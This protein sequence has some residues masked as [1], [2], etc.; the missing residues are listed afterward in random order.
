MRP[1]RASGSVITWWNAVA[2]SAAGASIKNACTLRLMA[3]LRRAST[4]SGARR[5]N[6]RSERVVS[7]DM[8]RQ[9]FLGRERDAL[10]NGPRRKLLQGHELGARD[11]LREHELHLEVREGHPDAAS[12]AA[13]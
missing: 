11:D 6:L 2:S 7:S 8:D 5:V 4:T 9:S 3:V 10:A 12:R 1:K 13:A